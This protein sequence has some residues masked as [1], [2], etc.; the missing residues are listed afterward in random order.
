MSLLRKCLDSTGR[1]HDRRVSALSRR[2][3]NPPMES[4]Y[5]WW[6]CLMT[7]QRQTGWWND[8]ADESDDSAKTGWWW[9]GGGCTQ[10]SSMNEWKAGDNHIRKIAARWLANIEGVSLCYWT[11]NWVC[12]RVVFLSELLQELL[13]GDILIVSSIYCIYQQINYSHHTLISWLNLSPWGGCALTWTSL[14]SRL[15]E[16]YTLIW[17]NTNILSLMWRKY[18]IVTC[19]SLVLYQSGKLY[20]ALLMQGF[21]RVLKSLEKSKIWQSQF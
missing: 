2:S 11:K 9:K 16:T 12:E 15:C 7:L 17:I 18:T 14:N 4:K 19:F 1:F 5:W 10:N 13:H 3:K 20:T 8:E 6:W 21:C